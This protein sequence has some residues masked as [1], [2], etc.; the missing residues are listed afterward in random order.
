MLRK[1]K[2]VN[3]NIRITNKSLYS[4]LPRLSRLIRKRRLKLAGHILRGNEPATKLLLWEP[5]HKQRRK[6][7]PNKTLKKVIE[8]DTGLTKD[9]IIQLA[10]NRE[11]WREM[12]MS[13]LQVDD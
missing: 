2:N 13:S 6:G 8:E 11:L 9:E 7:R 1:V 4:K 5:E 10:S 12:V 3:P